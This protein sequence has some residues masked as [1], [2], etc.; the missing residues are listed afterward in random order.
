MEK[1]ITH[2][3]TLR[4]VLFSAMRLSDAIADICTLKEEDAKAK[5]KEYKE[6][7]NQVMKDFYDMK[8]DE[9]KYARI[10]YTNL[11]T[12]LLDL[13]KELDDIED[14]RKAANGED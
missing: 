3:E 1:S 5:R 4:K 7:G 11:A 8:A 6:A 2:E 9:E 13:V 10:G 12:H 14:Y